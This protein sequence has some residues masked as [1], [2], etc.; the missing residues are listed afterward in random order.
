MKPQTAKYTFYISTY[1]LGR[2]DSYIRLHKD[3]LI[4]SVMYEIC[5]CQM[6]YKYP[7]AQFTHLHSVVEN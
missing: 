5:A 2:V 7:T 1:H 4:V 6:S 3:S